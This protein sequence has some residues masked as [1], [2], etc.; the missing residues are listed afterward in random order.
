MG[1]KYQ[2]ITVNFVPIFGADEAP[3]TAAVEADVDAPRATTTASAQR[4]AA[5][6][7][8]VG[9]PRATTTASVAISKAMDSGVSI[10]HIICFLKGRQE[11]WNAVVGCYT[12]NITN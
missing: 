5:V 1:R 8:E 2:V 9:A 10:L 6:E 4:V 7:M 11:K 12:W 3:R